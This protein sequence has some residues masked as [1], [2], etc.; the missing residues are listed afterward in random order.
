MQI[1]CCNLK[2]AVSRRSQWRWLCVTGTLCGRKTWPWLV[3]PLSGGKDGIEKKVDIL[4]LGLHCV[5]VNMQRRAVVAVGST[6]C[7][8][9]HS[10]SQRPDLEVG[11]YQ[12]PRSLHLLCPIPAMPHQTAT[13]LTSTAYISSACLLTVLLK[14]NQTCAYAELFQWNPFEA[15]HGGTLCNPSYLGNR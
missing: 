10:R 1:C 12:S 8:R 11:W 3:D 9:T 4:A 14:R 5:D 2:A 15:G 7:Q 13:V 6:H